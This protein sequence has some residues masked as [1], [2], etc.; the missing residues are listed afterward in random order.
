MITILWLD[1]VSKGYTDLLQEELF[2]TEGD[3]LGITHSVRGPQNRLYEAM[4]DVHI[5]GSIA[6]L[7]YSP[8]HDFNLQND[9][10]LGIMRVQFTDETRKEIKNILWK[11]PERDFTL[12]PVLV[13]KDNTSG[14]GA[15]PQWTEVEYK[16][17]VEAY[18]W[19]LEQERNGKPY[20]K[21]EVNKTLR[22]GALAARSK[23]SVEFRMRNISAVLEELCLPW[24][25]GYVPAG[26]IRGEGKDKIK[27][28]LANAGA[29]SPEDY[30]PTDDPDILDQRV[31]DL[32]M[33]LNPLSDPAGNK[34]PQQITGTVTRYVRD[35][36]V[37]ASVLK[38]AEGVCEGCRVAAP[39]TDGYGQ[40]FL[41]VHH[42]KQ[43]SEKGSDTVTNAVAL[44]PNCHRRCHHAGDRDIFIDTIYL[45][46]SRLIRE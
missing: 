10:L 41:E 44:C 32:K 43:L 39:F 1:D 37:K 18:L 36:T 40:P 3:T 30:A 33:K 21:S 24:I 38:K 17:T 5:K 26:N 25:K 15:T 8:Y 6:D 23:P 9:M 12:C 2:Q 20:N 27:F 7:N 16:A 14:T 4:C 31:R 45:N 11:E 46:I 19:M 29:Y 42:L 13:G 28:Y 34:T 22:E 35:P